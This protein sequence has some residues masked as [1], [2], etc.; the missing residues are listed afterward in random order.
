MVDLVDCC[1]SAYEKIP[2][3]IKRSFSVIFFSSLVVFS[4]SII[5]YFLGREDWSYAVVQTELF[6]WDLVQGRYFTR[7][8]HFFIFDGYACLPIIGKLFALFMLSIASIMLGVYWRLPKNTLSY[9]LIGI[10]IILQPYILGVFYFA[11]GTEIFLVLPFF[12]MLG[13]LLCEKVKDFRLWYKILLL[14]CSALCFWFIF[15]TYPVL[16]NTLVV[17]FVGR[18]LIDFILSK[19]KKLLQ[20]ISSHMYAIVAI[21]VGLLLHFAV[22]SWL[23]QKGIMDNDGYNSSLIGMSEWPARMWAVIRTALKYLSCYRISFFPDF[24]TWIW[25]FLLCLAGGSTVLD[26]IREKCNYNKRVINIIIVV[27]LFFCAL[28]GTLCTNIISKGTT[29]FRISVD[30]FGIAFFHALIL[31]VLF[32]INR[33]IIKN[34]TFLCCIVLLWICILQDFNI[35]KVWYF[36]FEAEKAQWYRIIDRIETKPEFNADKSY[37]LLILGTTEAYRPYFYVNR[38]NTVMKSSELLTLPFMASWGGAHFLPLNHYSAY[39]YKG[40]WMQ[41]PKEWDPVGFKQALESVKDELAK[42]EP[43]PAITS[44]QIKNDIILLVLDKNVLAEAKTLVNLN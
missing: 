40:K 32:N 43:W 23:R 7:F 24:F 27:L 2:K 19:D 9:S 3:Y 26:F 14:V 25:T 6:S 31:A 5:H 1:I 30:F 36:G 4:F 22:I 21:A 33:V 8:L 11:V 13:L 44:V 18:I 42:A 38:K 39:G 28:F 34:I 35:Q 29:F 16:I 12:L 20:L 37:R 41:I 17:I 15:G 10:A